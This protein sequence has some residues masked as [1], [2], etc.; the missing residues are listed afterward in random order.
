MKRTFIAI[1]VSP[2]AG[3]KRQIREL[4][5]KL[6]NEKLYWLR[7]QDLHLTVYFVGN[8]SEE[9]E[10]MLKELLKRFS[11]SASP[12]CISIS[13]LGYFKR[14]GKVKIFYADVAESPELE[15]FVAKFRQELTG[16]GFKVGEHP[17][18][19]HIT[20]ARVR[21]MS[22]PDTFEKL[23]SESGHEVSQEVIVD[24]L[25]FYQSLLSAEGSIYEPIE[26]FSLQQ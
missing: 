22:D 14:K 10:E 24:G 18:K 4:K 7:E 5:D 20:L 19:A 21:H 13:S 2:D 16:L 1:K 9:Q 25:C 12:F 26:N 11:Q 17:F 8:T 23:I 15:E 6:N 3:L